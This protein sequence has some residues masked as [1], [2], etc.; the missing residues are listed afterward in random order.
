[1]ETFLAVLDDLGA[2]LGMLVTTEGYSAA[3]KNRARSARGIRAEVLTLHELER[4][5]PAGTVHMACRLSRSRVQD[6]RRVLV[7]VGLRV[8]EDQELERAADQ[9]VLEVYRY[10]LGDEAPS[11]FDVTSAALNDAAIEFEHAGGGSTVGGGT[12]AHRWLAVLVEGEATQLRVLVDSETEIDRQLA[13]LADQFNV[14]RDRLDVQRPAEWPI[15]GLFG[16]PG[17]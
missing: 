17:G 2:D 5:S 8:A 7:E 15:V 10:Q 9:A 3:A 11:L 16:L 14:P 12:P 1:M 6:A 13:K 4:W